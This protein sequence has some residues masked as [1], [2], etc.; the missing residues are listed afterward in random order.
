MYGKHV[1]LNNVNHAKPTGRKPPGIVHLKKHQIKW[2]EELLKKGYKL[3]RRRKH[4]H[5][6]CHFEEC[7]KI[8]ERGFIF[9]SREGAK[10]PHLHFQAVYNHIQRQAPR[11]EKN[12]TYRDPITPLIPGRGTSCRNTFGKL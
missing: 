1:H 9:T 10:R 5:G 4:K 2:L 11:F 12:P 6:E 7:Y 3:Q 8:P